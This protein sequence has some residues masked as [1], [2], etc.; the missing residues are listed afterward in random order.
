MKQTKLVCLKMSG[1]RTKEPSPWDGGLS[2]FPQAFPL[3]SV[4]RKIHKALRLI[5]GG[6]KDGRKISR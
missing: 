3:T 4:L 5:S 2:N 6:Q 1:G